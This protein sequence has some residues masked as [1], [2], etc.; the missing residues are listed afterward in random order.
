[1][2]PALARIRRTAPLLLVVTVLATLLPS[3]PAGADP[4]SEG[5]SPSVWK[6]L[7]TAARNYN[8]AKAKLDATARQQ[9]QLARQL[10]EGQRR[11]DAL[12]RDIGHIA[13]AKYRTGGTSLLTISFTS[14]SPGDFLAMA[15]TLTYLGSQ[16]AQRMGRL[17]AERRSQDAKRRSLT[18]TAGRQKKQVALLKKRKGEAQKAVDAV[19]GGPGSGY[20]GGSASA[21]PAPRNPDGSWPSESCS[22]DDPT[23]SG[24]LTPR[25]LHAYQE[26][27]KAGYTRFT[28]CYRSQED[29]GEHPRG[30]ACD[31]SVTADGFGGEASG[32]ARTYGN[33]LAAWFIANA[34]R[35]AVL[36][37]IFFRQIW[38]PG[39]GWQAYNGSGSPSA[40]HTNHVHLSVQ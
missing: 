29:G 4:G 20:S 32:E 13:A 34:D 17:R 9:K 5:G 11:I 39:A 40:E 7:E 16:D 33:N 26:A 15:D 8:D 21:E 23:T 30:R 25:T 31:F 35:L 18:E 6:K 36:Y 24:C 10:A 3:G 19:S 2:P 12:S 28:S 14:S 22:V 37:V 27:R 1:M 38:L